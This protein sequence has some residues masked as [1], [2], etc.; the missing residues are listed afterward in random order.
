M[1]RIII[2]LINEADIK[3]SQMGR[4]TSRVKINVGQ[5]TIPQIVCSRRKSQGA[6]VGKQ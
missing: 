1:Y 2:D 3:V 5:P 4:K 6:K